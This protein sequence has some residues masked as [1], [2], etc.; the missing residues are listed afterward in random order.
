MGFIHDLNKFLHYRRLLTLLPQLLLIF[1][2]SYRTKTL[3]RIEWVLFLL[4]PLIFCIL[5]FLLLLVVET[6]FQISLG[7][8]SGLS[9]GGQGQLDLLGTRLQLLFL[10]FFEQIDH[11]LVRVLLRQFMR[12][13]LAVLAVDHDSCTATCVITLCGS[14]P[15]IATP[16]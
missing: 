5:G 6:R 13:R 10:I 11:L 4:C 12:C 8:I 15:C 14:L 1:I 7:V 9:V 3:E 2:F 16:R